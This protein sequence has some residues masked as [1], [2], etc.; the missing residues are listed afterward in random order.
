MARP[1][2]VIHPF[3][4]AVATTSRPQSSVSRGRAASPLTESTRRRGPRARTIP[5]IVR[6]SFVTPVA[7]SLWVRRTARIEASAASARSTA[8]GSAGTPGSKERRGT[9]G[10]WAPAVSAKRAP[11]GP[12]LPARAGAPGGGGVTAAGPRAPVPDAVRRRTSLRVRKTAWRRCTVRRWRETNS[13]PRWSIIGAAPA[14]RTSGGE[15]VGPGIRRFTGREGRADSPRPWGEAG[16]GARSRRPPR[17]TGGGRGRRRSS[18]ARSSARGR[19][20]RAPAAGGTTLRGRGRR[21]LRALLRGSLLLVP[22][23][24]P[25]SLLAP[26]LSSGAAF[27]FGVRS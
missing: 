12:T 10:P 15:G 18:S 4:E 19:S 27:S 5:A 21:L 9:A 23:L 3:W 11:N 13:S 8:A 22:L 2:G 7:V 6:T 24:P 26:F 1:G 16:R 20:G 25:L 14:S 17:R